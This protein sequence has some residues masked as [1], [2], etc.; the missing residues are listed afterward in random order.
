[1]EVVEQVVCV[2]FVRT[3]VNNSH[4]LFKTFGYPEFVIVF[5]LCNAAKNIT[6][7]TL[8]R[9]CLS[10]AIIGPSLLHF[11]ARKRPLDNH[12]F[13]P[14]CADIQAMTRIVTTLSAIENVANL[15]LHHLM[16]FQGS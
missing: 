10:T 1:M 16:C 7:L 4:L 13:N 6:L 5:A 8:V 14:D 15:V 11:S 3:L 9:A 2:V 12:S